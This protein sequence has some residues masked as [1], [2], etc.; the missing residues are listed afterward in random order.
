[1]LS[2]GADPNEAFA[3]RSLLSYAAAQGNTPILRL[4]LDAGAP[5]DW[6]ALQMAA[7]RNHAK[8][9]QLLLAAGAPTDAGKGDTPL[10]NALKYS[11]TSPEDPGR[12]R[13]RQLLREAGARELPGWYLGWRWTILYGWR[14]RFRRLL[15][16]I[17]WLP[18]RRRDGR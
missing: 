14:W 3:V 13:V 16:S 2:V 9:V 15:Y 6:N 11:G 12:V 10:L 8:A 4:L 17:G 18:K 5:A 7:Y 1:L